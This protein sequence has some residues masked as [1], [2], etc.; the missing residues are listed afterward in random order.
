MI[1]CHREQ[2]GQLHPCLHH[3]HRAVKISSGTEWLHKGWRSKHCW[4]KTAIKVLFSGQPEVILY[5]ESAPRKNV[6][7]TLHLY[8]YRGNC[9]LSFS[10]QL[11][12]QWY[13][14][15]TLPSDTIKLW[16]STEEKTQNPPWNSPKQQEDGGNWGKEKPLEA[17]VLPKAPFQTWQI[18]S[19]HPTEVQQLC[20]AVSGCSGLA[21][22]REGVC[23]HPFAT[24]CDPTALTL[25]HQHRLQPV[26][27]NVGQPDLSVWLG[28]R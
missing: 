2:Q 14:T 10:N 26:S 7:K 1:C 20:C 4:G 6:F 9:W 21:L 17:N 19:V 23:Q 22:P 8:H 12:S 28:S 11:L 5:P 3:L 25:L 16:N 18:Y 24:G 27:T 13:K 15:R